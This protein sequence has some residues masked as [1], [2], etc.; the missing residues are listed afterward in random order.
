VTAICAA[1]V[2][3]LAF[4]VA[5]PNTKPIVFWHWLVLGLLL[6]VAALSKLQALGLF[7]LSAL[8]ALLMAWQRKDWMLPL[9]ALVPVVLPPLLIAGW[10]YARNFRLYG[11]WSG[12]GFLL[13]I[14]GRRAGDFDFA[15]W[16]LEFRGLRYSFW[17]LFGWFNILLP[18]WVYWL[19]DAATVAA[20]AGA[21]VAMVRVLRRPG[22]SDGATRVLALCAVWA[23]ISFALLVYWTLRATGSQGRLLFPAISALAILFVLGISNWLRYA[24]RWVHHSVW[25]TVLCLLLA[26]SV[27]ALIVVLPSAYRPDDAVVTVP[28]NSNPVEITFGGAEPI[29]LRAVTVA[30]ERFKPG[31]E[32]PVTLY[33]S[34]P[35]SLTRNYELFLQLLDE[36]GREVANVTTHPGWGRNPTSLWLPGA[37]YPDDYRLR[38]IG[39]IESRSPLL[40]RLYTGFIDPDTSDQGNLPLVARDASGAE[41]TPFV[42]E[43]TLSPFDPPTLESENMDA[44][45]ATFEDG[46]RLAG[47][48]T[49]LS[50]GTT[51]TRTLTVTVLYEAT[52]TPSADYTAFVHLRNTEGTT[53]AGYDQQPAAGRFPTSA[54]QADDTILSTFHLEIPVDTPPGRYEL[55]SGLY[56]STSAGTD[57][58]PIADSMGMATQDHA[59]RLGEV[60]LEP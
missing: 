42:G 43:V 6:G 53:V 39:P 60:N 51:D 50:A 45:G 3:W 33:L 44:V 48:S 25:T 23:G 41:L 54:W 26:S 49:S 1:T 37:I 15:D 47:A 16:W 4:L 18:T 52:G 17:G 13:E 34:A 28:A 7:L 59:V 46:I 12:L 35:I 9:R 21:I 31:D 11:D 55:W 8:A 10:W 2:A 20:L 27:Y 58:L 57:R 14:N 32:V 5:K 30:E 38:I 40:A 36:D 19:L 24:P 29:E 22:L 56:K